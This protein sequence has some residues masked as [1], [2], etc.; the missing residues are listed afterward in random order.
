[1]DGLAAMSCQNEVNADVISFPAFLVILRGET[2]LGAKDL[3]MLKSADTGGKFQIEHFLEL[4]L[5]KVI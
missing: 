5:L 3:S 4:A 1:M 2:S